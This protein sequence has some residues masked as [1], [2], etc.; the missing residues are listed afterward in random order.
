MKLLILVA[1]VG[2]AAANLGESEYQTLWNQFK[3]DFAKEY[4][5]VVEH[6]ARYSTFKDNVDFIY[7][8]NANADE[9][10]FTVAI[11]QFADMTRQEFKKTMLTYQA[12]KKVQ[13]NI[14]LLDESATADSVDWVSKGAVTP[15]KNQGQCGSCWAFSTTG[16][17][18]GAYQIATG[19]LKSFSEQELVVCAGSYG[20]QG[21]NG[22]LMDDGFKYLEA[23]GD[24]LESAYSYTGKTGT[25]STSKQSDAALK[26]GQVTSF[27]DVTSDSETQ[28][29]AAVSKGPV[30]VAIEADQSGFQF[31]KTGVF[32]GTC[33]TNLDHGVLVVGYGTDSGSDYWKVKNS[34]GTTWGLD[35]YI[36]LKRGNATQTG[37]KLLGGGGGGGAS[38]ECGLLKQPSYP[39]VK[40]S[41]ASSGNIYRIPITKRSNEEVL[42]GRLF[43]SQKLGADASPA[44][45]KINDFQNAQY[46]GEVQVGTPPQ[47]FQ[48]IFDT[49]S[50]NLW[51]PNKKVGLIGLF[52]DKYDSSK[53]STY[54]SNGTEFKIQYGSGPV[55][56]I[57]SSDKITLGDLEVPKQAFAEVED[58]GGLGLAY[59][60]GKFDGILGL[61]W[62]RISVDGVETVMSNLVNGG[63][64]ADKV[65]A[66]YLADSAPGALVIGGTDKSHYTGDF[67]YVPLKSEDY[68][69]IALDD[70]KV[71]GTSYTT[72]KTAIVDSGT[73]LLAGPKAEVA[74][75]AAKIGATSILGGKEYTIACDAKAPDLVFTIA[76][77]DYTFTMKDY[78]ISSGGT[79]LFAM[80]GIDV[81]APNGPLW[82]LGDVFMRKYYTVF[83]WGNKQLGFALAK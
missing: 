44:D 81:P 13:N 27:N 64:L 33:G 41:V 6:D 48:V 62:D 60:I 32:S 17:T 66:F 49:G 12:E 25:C 3:V 19:S 53:S 59:G 37:R 61:G 35:G 51:V 74:K 22:G 24:A 38:G 52:K 28:M 5:E 18:E 10:G 30:S 31:Y 42:K 78:T 75:L 8:H 80:T 82:I 21:C 2:A 71:D 72:T 54:V 23:K 20:N 47:N 26:V 4:T 45:I 55:S 63:E 14:V 79:C 50:A 69:R 73:S 36:M 56:G 77:K 16:S 40:S 65:F 29:L 1:L 11:N 34:W 83:D 7:S 46:Y 9:H 70:L 15:V 67:T 68:W 57:W 76:G 43:A 39:V 58:A